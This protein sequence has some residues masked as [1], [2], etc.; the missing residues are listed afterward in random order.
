MALV[1]RIGES[2]AELLIAPRFA[3]VLGRAAAGCFEEHGLCKADD[4]KGALDLDAVR[5]SRRRSRKDT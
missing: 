4:G 1:G 3:D 5:T 2:L